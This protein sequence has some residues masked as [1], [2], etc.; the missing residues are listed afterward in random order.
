MRVL[1][2]AL[3]V[4]II[5]L[6]PVP[7]S[8]DVVDYIGKP[9]GSVRLELDGRE[10]NDQTLL[11]VVETQPGRPLSMAEVRE[12]V[13]HLFS[14]GR[15]EDVQVHAAL[16]GGSVALRYD[17]A[18]IHHVGKV[19]FAGDLHVPGVDTGQLREAIV[20]RFGASPPVGRAADVA[21]LLVDELRQRG[22]LHAAVSPR[23]DIER[24]S[25]RA[26]LVFTVNPG[27]RTRIGTVDIVG[28]PSVP[29]QTFLSELG[30]APG[31]PFERDVL[32]RRIDKYVA[33]R[34]AKGFY[35]A[36]VVPAAQLA[37]DDR[38]VN[39]TLT[40]APGPR[41]RVIFAGDP[42]PSDK[43][44]ELAPVQREGSVD[45]DLLEDSTNRIEEYLHE[46]GYR[47]ALAPHTREQ[48]PDELRITFTVKKGAQYRVSRVEI[49]GNASVPIGEFGP[50]LRQRDGQPFSAAKLEADLSAIES[51]YHRRG[52]AAAKAEAALEQ[53]DAVPGAAQ[54]LV[55]VRMTIRE[56]VR[57]IVA[58]VAIV[59]NQS[60]AEAALRPSLGLQP[61]EPFFLPRLAVDRDALQ[62]QYA[63]LG[64][65]SATVDTNPGMTADLTRAN[66]VFTVHEGPRIFVD[67]V[68]IVGNVRTRTDTITRELQLKPGDPLG[69]QAVSDSQRRLAALGLFRRTRITEVRHG[70]E[71]RRDLLV[72]VE[73]A[74][75]TTVGYG[76]GGEAGQRGAAAQGGLGQ[77][78]IDFAPRAFF[79]T[80]RRNLFGK[81]RSV[82]LFGR[83]SLH[84]NTL[85]T[86]LAT[87]SGFTEYRL[88]ASFR[89]PRVLNTRADASLTG[90]IEQQQRPSFNFARR[91]FIAE[92]GRRLARGVS[93]SG[94][95]QIQRTKLF[96]D[97]QFDPTLLPLVDRLFPQVLLSS[98]ASS[99]ARDTR[100]DVV[101]PG[102]GGYLSASGQLAA[103]RIGSA[104]GLA[105]TFLT[106]QAFR[107]LPHS[108]RVVLAGNVRVGLATGF[109]RDVVR[110]DDHGQVIVGTDGLPIVDR[111]VDLP[112]SERFFA[113]G[114]TMRGFALD[115]LGAPKTINKN[116]VPIGG[117]ALVLVNAE[118]RVPVRGGFGVVGFFDT[119]NVFEHTTDVNLGELRSA[120]GFGLRY[121]SPIGPIRFDLGFKLRPRTI[122]GRREDLTAF[123]ISLGQA[124]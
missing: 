116:G 57:T 83:I 96:V 54:M 41:V 1:G 40:V 60:V 81:N 56:G 75:V 49:S 22:Y 111:V 74:P 106:A 103:R 119:G 37:D 98:F 86:G 33:G 28:T 117:N 38:V 87:A 17:L 70:D 6:T 25:A 72:T 100:D 45:E 48:T 53:Q 36:S 21:R 71:T 78:R 3:A 2:L 114:D 123:H 16:A 82:N 29:R 59:G 68:L 52:F 13:M 115:Q 104:V 85:G 50:G 102:A 118:S 97:P 47:D 113:G 95:Y 79:E 55:L 94:S 4:A 62:I 64:Y 46:Q 8:A 73:E 26:T 124:F 88:L 99:I 43:H 30:I 120:V 27:A 109:P 63:N 42:I 9:V 69:R 90:V 18:P 122:A 93:L 108:R 10:T 77:T 65:Q 24:A 101:D 51:L 44:D 84:S 58:S 80:T 34:R 76:G 66:V 7:A 67:H 107:T 91:S 32:S 12:S 20:E 31:A 105:K 39:L 110:T 92:A 5:T 19:A 11:A 14:L 61:G 35:E 121:R 89:E 23:A 112:A 15:F